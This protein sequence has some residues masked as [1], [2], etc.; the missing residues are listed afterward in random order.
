MRQSCEST[1]KPKLL[2]SVPCSLYAA[3]VI[4]FK[5]RNVVCRDPSPLCNRGGIMTILEH[6][7]KRHDF[8]SV[9]EEPSH[10]CLSTRFESQFVC[11]LGSLEAIQTFKRELVKQSQVEH[12]I[13]VY[14]IYVCVCV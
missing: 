6:R 4:L 5:L 7:F 3:C 14:I 9:F 13:Y 12:N 1:L 11:S 10:F 8:S 2:N